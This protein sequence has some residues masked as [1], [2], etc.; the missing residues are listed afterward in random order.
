MLAKELGMKERN[1]I[2]PELGMQVELTPDTIKVAG[3]VQAGSVLIDG[4]G[5][6]EKDSNVIRDRLLLSQDGV[7]VVVAT[8][9]SKSGR[10]VREPDIIS[11]GFVYQDE[12]SDIIKEA[13]EFIYD[14]LSDLDLKSMDKAEIRANIRKV[15]TN[16]FFKHTKRKPVILSVIVETE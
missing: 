8:L 5:L 13:K 9:S 16:F 6:G 1:I 11:R 7:C 15:S 12:A 2:I 4:T 14:K 3:M 10:L